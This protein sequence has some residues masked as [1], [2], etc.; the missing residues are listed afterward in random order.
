ME[1]EKTAKGDGREKQDGEDGWEKRE[2]SKG[3]QNEYARLKRKVVEEEE[4]RGG[5]H[6]V[7]RITV[8]GNLNLILT[9]TTMGK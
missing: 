3:G 1:R 6:R 5:W 2:D 9:L 7:L 8:S 4:R